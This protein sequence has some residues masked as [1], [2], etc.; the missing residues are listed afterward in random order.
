MD[1][2][3]VKSAS[4]C[5]KDGDGNLL[6]KHTPQERSKFSL[7][8][9]FIHRRAIYSTSLF[10]RG[11]MKDSGIGRENGIEAYLACTFSI[12]LCLCE[13]LKL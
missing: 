1:E 13:Q 7:V 3:F 5:C 4:C 6:G 12:R 9:K 8:R 2:R 10:A 11:G